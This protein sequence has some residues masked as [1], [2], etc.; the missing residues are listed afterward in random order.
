MAT[1]NYVGWRVPEKVIIVAKDYRH[2]E[3]GKYT[4][5]GTYQGYVVDAGNKEML[6]SARNWAKWTEYVQPYDRETR[7]YAAVIDH[8]GIEHE[9][10]N[11]GFT[12]TLLDSANGSSQGG[13]LSFWNCKISKG[14]KEFIIGIASDYL[15]EIL[16]HNTFINGTC[17]STLSFARCKGGVGMMNKEMPSYQQ[18]MQDEQHRAAMKKGK[19]KKREPGHLYSTLTGGDVY[20]S[21]F[22]KWYEPVYS[23]DYSRYRFDK[24]L[25]GF[26]KLDTPVA[27]YWEPFYNE[28]YTKKSEYFE[29]SFY[30]SSN[31]PARVDSGCA[32]E[33]DITDEEVLKKQFEKVFKADTPT[34]HFDYYVGIGLDKNGYTMPEW[35]CKFLVE[36]GY[37]IWD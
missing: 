6:E 34:Y 18:F 8:E 23:E 27:V 1:S 15:L 21:T 35:Q 22:Y 17:Q 20:F 12:L 16:L 13:K 32:A 33:I 19:T 5:D 37:K 36:K 14:D 24:K 31:T 26:K 28:K 10:D 4:I 3:N 7:T 30:F 29:R 9:F 25:L 11:E 2:W